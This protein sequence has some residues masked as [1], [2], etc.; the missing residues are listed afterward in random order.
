MLERIDNSDLEPVRALGACGVRLARVEHH[1]VRVS[2]APVMD[3]SFA[4]GPPMGT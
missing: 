3:D 1:A 2:A 4:V